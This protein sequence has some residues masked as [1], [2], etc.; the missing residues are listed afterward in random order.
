VHGATTRDRA[1]I[2]LSKPRVPKYSSQSIAS[3][4]TG[5]W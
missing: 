4:I 3:G 1:V 2:S 5:E